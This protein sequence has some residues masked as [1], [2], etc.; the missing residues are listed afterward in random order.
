[1]TDTHD[2]CKLASHSPHRFVLKSN[3]FVNAFNDGIPFKIYNTR[4]ELVY[5]IGKKFYMF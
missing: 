5:Q 4:N 1:M 3:D 2:P